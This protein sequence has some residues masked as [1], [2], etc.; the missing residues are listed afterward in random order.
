MK[1]FDL[2]VF[3]LSLFELVRENVR[4]PFNHLPFP[5]AHLRRVQLALGCDLLHRLVTA[6]RL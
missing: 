3:V 2:A 5:S 1:L 6:Q 4:H